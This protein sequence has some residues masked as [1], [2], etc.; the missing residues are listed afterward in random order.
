MRAGFGFSLQGA[1]IFR[2]WGKE[3][4]GGAGQ[5]AMATVALELGSLAHKN[6]TL[7]HEEAEPSSNRAKQA[8]AREQPRINTELRAKAA[9]LETVYS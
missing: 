4:G 1:F 7:K 8:Y 2:G 6:V 3:G 9:V 5:Q